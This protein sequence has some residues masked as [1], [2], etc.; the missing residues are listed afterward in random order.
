ML[1]TRPR[2]RIT[3]ATANHGAATRACIMHEPARGTNCIYAS[4][5]EVRIKGLLPR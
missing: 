3:I 4:G 2:V 5:Y 1:G